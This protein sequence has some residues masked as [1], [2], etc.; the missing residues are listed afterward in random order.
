[1]GLKS[2]WMLK[3]MVQNVFSVLP[4][5]HRLYN[6]LLEYVLRPLPKYH[7]RLHMLPDEFEHKLRQS[8]QHIEHYLSARAQYG[9]S[10]SW[11]LTKDGIQ[12]IRVLE[13]GTGWFPVV[14][15][16]LY[17]CG[18]SEVWTVDIVSHFKLDK[19]KYI[20]DLFVR[21][22]RDG[23]LSKILP[24]VDQ[25]RLDTV[26][27]LISSPDNNGDDLMKKL[28]IYRLVADARRI[29]IRSGTV[30][31]FVSNNVLEHIPREILL[32]IYHEFARLA[33]N[34][35]VMAHYID[36][37]DHHSYVDESITRYNYRKYNKHVWWFFNNSINHQN[38]LCLSD[39][40]E[41]HD[42]AGWKIVYEE[43]AKGNSDELGKKI[44]VSKDFHKYP[45]WEW[46]VDWCWLVSI[47]DELTAREQM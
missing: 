7:D 11:E 38:R 25:S 1:M 18:A 10:N 16:A 41:L 13:L 12:G 43:I 5:G 17:L 30:D 45:R 4:Q 24:S 15:V 27:R 23:K 40:K 20:T 32:G 22:A 33:A 31:L 2:S 6:L 37:G 28:G 21:Y 29:K 46:F 36:M 47:R 19:V 39:Y 44:R 34:R 26:E 42:T 14:P 35:A 8:Q 9:T 3:A